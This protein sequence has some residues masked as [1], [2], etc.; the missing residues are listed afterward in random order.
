MD[1]YINRNALLFDLSTSFVPQSTTY[2]DAVGIAIRWIKQA[3]AADVVPR[4]AFDQVMWE[5]D[6]AIKQLRE[7]Y[8]VGLGEKRNADVVEV[9]RGRWYWAEDG[10][11]KCSECGQYAV[12]KRVVVKTNFCPNCGADMREVTE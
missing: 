12:V 11:C 4:G 9:K 6:V 5:R 3:P 8:G 10:H 7:D 1:E 2:T